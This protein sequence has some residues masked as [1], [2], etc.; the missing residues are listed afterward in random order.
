M[1]SGSLRLGACLEVLAGG[2]CAT[3]RAADQIHAP[4]SLLQ[5]GSPAGACERAAD[6]SG[7]GACGFGG[8]VGSTAA[9]RWPSGSGWWVEAPDSVDGGERMCSRQAGRGPERYFAGV[10]PAAPERRHPRASGQAVLLVVVSALKE[11]YAVVSN[12][13]HE[14]VLLGDSPRPHAGRQMSQAFRLAD[15]VKGIARDGVDEIHDS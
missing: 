7:L 10:T 9:L 5:R 14:S 3:R 11:I 4:G 6:P 8:R 2:G 12:Q 13:V 1:G 15:S